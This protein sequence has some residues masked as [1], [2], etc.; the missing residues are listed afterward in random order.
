MRRMTAK[1]WLAVAV[2]VIT[3]AGVGAAAVKL[4]RFRAACAAVERLGGRISYERPQWVGGVAGGRPLPWLD[5]VSSIDLAGCRLDD[6]GFS[7][8]AGRLDQFP[9]LSL[10]RL[11]GT[12]VGDRAAVELHRLRL[13][14]RNLDLAGTRLGDDGVGIV[15]R[16]STLE[17]LDL[18]GT[19]VSDRGV[20]RL[21]A[22]GRLRYLNLDNTAVS[23]RGIVALAPLSRLS[24]L[25]VSNTGVTD[26]GVARLTAALPEMD[27][28]DD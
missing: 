28:F 20:R 13:P 17:S 12:Q 24:E 19:A 22:L 8:L 1:R 21:A 9:D 16:I 7:E 26:D 14:L 4:H 18:S 15:A 3:A 27:V 2:A 23:D 5:T 11:A 6:A 25:N 10:L